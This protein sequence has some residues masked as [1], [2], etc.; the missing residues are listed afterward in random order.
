MVNVRASF[1]DVLAALPEA[2][3]AALTC[4]PGITFYFCE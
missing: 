1:T 4:G 2:N 3:L